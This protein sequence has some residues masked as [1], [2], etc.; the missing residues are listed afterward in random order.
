VAARFADDDELVSSVD[1]VRGDFQM[2]QLL[3]NGSIRSWRLPGHPRALPWSTKLLRVAGQS[4]SG[5]GKE[6]QIHVRVFVN[7]ARWARPTRLVA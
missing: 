6:V 2:Q 3:E 7:T 4:N 5:I 1:C